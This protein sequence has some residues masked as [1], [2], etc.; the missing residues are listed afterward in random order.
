MY[1]QSRQNPSEVCQ[2]AGFTKFAVEAMEAVARG[3]PGG[4]CTT[5]GNQADRRVGV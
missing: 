4:V 2:V 1:W 5:H 3:E